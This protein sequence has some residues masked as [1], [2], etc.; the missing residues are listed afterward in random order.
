V[1][2]IAPSDEMWRRCARALDPERLDRPEYRG[3][4]DRQKR[5]QEVIDAITA[6]T[7][8]LTSDELV[9]RLG[10][11]RVN[12]AKVNSV[13]EAADHAQLEAARGTLSFPFGGE[14]VKAV[15]SPFHLSA[16]PAALREPPPLLGQHTADILAELGIAED[17][18]ARSKPRAP[19]P[20]RARPL[21]SHPSLQ[22]PLCTP[23]ERPMDRRLPPP[24]RQRAGTALTDMSDSLLPLPHGSTSLSISLSREE[25]E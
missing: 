6:V 18:A 25:Q 22:P 15:T 10:A 4:T 5:R 21:S 7:S 9:E 3:I 8:T 1:V 12:V 20:G 14:T 17:E 11:V 24:C 23:L 2:I 19:S 16:T 13:G